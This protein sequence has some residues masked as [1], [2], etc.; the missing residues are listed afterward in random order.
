MAFV[1][2]LFEIGYM[3][4]HVATFFQILK[5]LKKNN[6][7]LVSFE[8]NVL[9][10]IGA[11]SRIGWMWDS[12]LKSFFL[13]YLEVLIAI[14]TLSYVIYLHQVNKVRNY[15]SNEIILPHYLKLYT[16]IPV[17]FVLSFL[18]NP[19]SSFFSS[20]VFVS[21]GIFS[22]AF[23]LLP[24]LFMIIKSRDTGDLSEM[25]IVFLGIARFFRLI[26]W[27]KM[28]MDGSKFLSLVIADLAHCVALSNFIYNVV[29]NWSGK[30]LPTSFTEL[31]TKSNKK[32]F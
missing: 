7:E 13:A 23:G 21:L 11:F 2:W 27:I 5:M 10:L 24:Q 8:T 3:F 30:G 19:G 31:N 32:M 29:M 12:M 4:Q 9:F 16:L 28:Y 15:Y 14:G 18:F 1:L 6:S 25:Y 26:F 17:V 22:E 20:Q